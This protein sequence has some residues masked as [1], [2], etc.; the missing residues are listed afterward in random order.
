M[1]IELAKLSPLQRDFLR[2]IAQHQRAK[3][4]RGGYICFA[5]QKPVCTRTVMA[6]Q[7]MSLV[8]FT[9]GT[10]VVMLTTEGTMLLNCGQVVISEAQSA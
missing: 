2:S 7:R 4:A 6:L 5:G 3:R 10:L 8:H 1:I 9:D